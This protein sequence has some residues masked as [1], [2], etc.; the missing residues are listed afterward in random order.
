MPLWPGAVKLLSAYA[1]RGSENGPTDV[2]IGT[3]A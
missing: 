2:W 1:V 3:P